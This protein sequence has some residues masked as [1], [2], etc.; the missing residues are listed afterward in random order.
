MLTQLFLNPNSLHGGQVVPNW[1]KAGLGTTGVL[2][3]VCP[4]VTL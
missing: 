1:S 4:S 2:D 3:S